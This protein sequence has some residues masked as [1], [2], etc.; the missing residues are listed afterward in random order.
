MVLFTPMKAP[1][2]ITA[3]ISVVR[4]AVNNPMTR[5]SRANSARFG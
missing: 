2:R 5:M 1:A 4:D 3:A